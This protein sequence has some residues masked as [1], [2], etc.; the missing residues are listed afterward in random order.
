MVRTVRLTQGP[1]VPH[2]S[3]GAKTLQFTSKLSLFLPYMQ[4]PLVVDIKKSKLR[5][6]AKA[7]VPSATVTR[8]PSPALNEQALM[9]REVPQP[10]A[11]ISVEDL[12]APDIPEEI[13]AAIVI[14][15]AYKRTLRRRAAPSP[16]DGKVKMWYDQ[17]VCARMRL[18]GPKKY[19][20]YFLGPLVHVLIWADSLVCLLKSRKEEVKKKFKNADHIQIEDLTERLTTCK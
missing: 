3:D 7:F 12:E 19:S 1:D 4:S 9:S 14:Q 11:T 10:V 5:A 8:A 13:K 20:K 15:V 16:Q 18:Q 17:C 2:L 6:T